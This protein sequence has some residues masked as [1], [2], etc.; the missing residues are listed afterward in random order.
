MINEDIILKSIENALCKCN[1]N[2]IPSDGSN[3]RIIKF[4]K[5]ERKRISEFIDLNCGEG[6]NYNPNEQ[7]RF[8]NAFGGENVRGDWRYPPIDGGPDSITTEDNELYR[9]VIEDLQRVYYESDLYGKP[10]QVHE[11]HNHPKSGGY[12]DKMPECLSDAD[13]LGCVSSPWSKSITAVSG[14]N[15]SKM[16]FMKGDDFVN[17]FESEAGILAEAYKLREAYFSYI[18]NW[19]S[20]TR[21]VWDDDEKN[22][23]II[24]K[25]VMDNYKGG[26]GIVP[27]IH[28][29]YEELAQNNIGSFEDSIKDIRSRLNKF[30]VDI[31]IEWD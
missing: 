2:S 19:E 25:E 29:R 30:N 7:L 13:I 23:G 22:G 5:K 1:R 27:K 31:S 26:G 10:F 21:K 6:D 3:L 20:E 11:I 15:K 12:R 18:S 24:A 16:I 9:M 14:A 8:I 17:D 4:N 28:A